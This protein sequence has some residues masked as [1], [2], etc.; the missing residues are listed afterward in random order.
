[1]VEN[2]A[3]ECD[4]FVIGNPLLDISGYY[5][6]DAMLTKYNL[7]KGAACLAEETQKPIYAE[8]LA[9]ESNKHIT[10]PGGAGLNSARAC[11]YLL[12]KY[13]VK[14]RG[15]AYF[16][17]V[18]KDNYADM[19]IE[20]C[21]KLDMMPVMSVNEE[22]PTGTCACVIVGKE[23]ALC[24][25]LA[26][27]CCYPTSH[28]NENMSYLASA[29]FV[30]ATA[31]FITSNAEAMKQVGRYCAENDKPMAFNIAAPFLLFTNFDEVMDA[32]EH[33]DYTFCNEDEASTFAEK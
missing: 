7:Q 18:G 25:N 9:D 12:R 10:S 29:K 30:Y 33:A 15:V 5:A 24:A 19:I 32:I 16:G 17:C 8:L 31:F 22:T 20:S 1:M 11:A 13:E 26:A 23:R 6:D 14:S 28:L 21:K 27:S 2:Q 4:I 3:N